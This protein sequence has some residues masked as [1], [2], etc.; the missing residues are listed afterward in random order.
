MRS[1]EPIR[2]TKRS[3]IEATAAEVVK[4]CRTFLDEAEVVQLEVTPYDPKTDEQNRQQHAWFKEAAKQNPQMSAEEYRAD[5]KAYI[6]IPILCRDSDEYRE[7]YDRL[8]R[9]LDPEIKLA[10][11]MRPIDFPVTRAMNKRQLSEYLDGVYRRLTT[12]YRIHLEK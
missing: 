10:Y 3:D 11:M 4:L 5:C 6:G 9:P 7:A 1:V 2:M 12:E 8:V